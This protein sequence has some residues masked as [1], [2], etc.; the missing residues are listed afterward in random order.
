MALAEELAALLLQQESLPEAIDFTNI[1]R[2]ST[3]GIQLMLSLAK[4]AEKLGHLLHLHAQNDHLPQTLTLLGLQEWW[5]QQQ[6][7]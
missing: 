7:E 3:P 4:T 1:S 2:F 6:Q 5:R